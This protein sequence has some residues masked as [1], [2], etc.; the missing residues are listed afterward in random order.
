MAKMLGLDQGDEMVRLWLVGTNGNFILKEDIDKYP[1]NVPLAFRSMS[2]RKVIKKCWED[3]RDFYYIDNGYI[4]NA[5]KKKWYYRV[6]KNN[7]QHVDKIVDVPNDR[8]QKMTQM[9]PWIVYKGQKA[10]PNNGPILLV[11]PSEKPGAFYGIT[12]DNWLEE[13]TKQL[14]KYTDRKIIVR[15][16][17]LRGDRIGD[18][19]IGAQCARDGVWAVV[20][21]QSIAALE[22]IHYGIPA[23]TCAPTATQHLANTNLSLIETP[24]YPDEGEFQKLLNYLTYCQYTPGE[25]GNGTAYRLIEELGL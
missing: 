13:T 6:V 14:R 15:D 24:M 8:F 22:A 11:T 16:K 20:T 23:F 21:Y 3:N 9:H 2:K 12:R 25:L 18:N 4:G 17:G 7:V 10:R 1:T 5:Q 19:S